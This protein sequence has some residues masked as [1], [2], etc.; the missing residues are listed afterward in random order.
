[1]FD[2][3]N[4]VMIWVCKYFMWCVGKNGYVEDDWC[5]NVK[6]IVSDYV[7]IG[8]WFDVVEIL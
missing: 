3:F 1:M 7:F 6:C 2:V 5:V 8:L 4:V